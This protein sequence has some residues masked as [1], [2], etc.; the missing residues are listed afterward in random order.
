MQ[1]AEI[2]GSGPAVDTSNMRFYTV[3]PGDTLISICRKLYGNL[4]NLEYIKGLNQLND[5]NLIYVD[6]EL[7]VP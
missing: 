1:T 3:K 2:G 7:L 5:E 4:E 6:Q